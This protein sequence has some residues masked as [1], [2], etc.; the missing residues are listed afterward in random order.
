MYPIS[1]FW[2]FPI[3]SMVSSIDNNSNSAWIS[4]LLKFYCVCYR[5][6]YIYSNPQRIGNLFRFYGLWC[7]IFS[8]IS[9]WCLLLICIIILGLAV[10]LYSI[11]CLP[12]ICILVLY[13]LAVYQ[14][15][16]VYG[17]GYFHAFCSSSYSNKML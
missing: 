6:I 5:Y 12:L 4:N 13:E 17:V 14:R 11:W 7:L 8:F 1:I 2:P 3:K 15:Y 10:K 9:L 16:I